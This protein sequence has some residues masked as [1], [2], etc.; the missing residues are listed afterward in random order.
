MNT[1][2]SQKYGVVV[3][4]GASG[5][6]GAAIAKKIAPDSKA[7]ILIARSKDKLQKIQSEL[8]QA[9]PR[10]KIQPILCDLTIAEH[11]KRLIADLAT[12]RIDTLILNAGSG[13]F[14]KF[15]EAKYS[16]HLKT[17]ELNIIANIDLTYHLVPTMNSTGR[18]QIITSHSN[19]MRIPNFSTY[20]PAKTFATLWAQTLALEQ[21][22][23]P[24]KF[25]IICAGAMATEF[26]PSAGIPKMVSKIATPDEIAVK[27]VRLLD[28]DGAHY[29]TLYDK[30]IW[31]LNRFLPRFF[32]DFLIARIQARYI[33]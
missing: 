23:T 18:V 25:S 33:K 24:M 2:E 6:L 21:K 10:T 14:K 30:I 8:R 19:E 27:C 15:F 31:A 5:G 11:R 17:I 16:D 3:I 13:V 29:L 32:I 9:N 7:L 26:G 12:L 20:A 22:D 1:P 28:R 4:T